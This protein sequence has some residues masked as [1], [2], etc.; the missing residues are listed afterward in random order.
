MRQQAG[1]VVSGISW[2]CYSPEWGH[3]SFLS[4]LGKLGLHSVR[5]LAFGCSDPRLC[6]CMPGCPCE[7]TCESEHAFLLVN[8]GL[9][10]SR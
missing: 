6:V 7:Y 10:V 1:W 2:C 8:V 3:V 9:R 4:L 5:V